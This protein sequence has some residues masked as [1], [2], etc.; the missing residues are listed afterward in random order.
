MAASAAVRALARSAVVLAGALSSSF[1]LADQRYTSAFSTWVAGRDHCAFWN[2][3]VFTLLKFVSD[4]VRSDLIRS[5][6]SF[7]VSER[8]R[9]ACSDE[10]GRLIST[11]GSVARG[12]RP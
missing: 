8:F 10:V 5:S 9:K 2:F 4:L 3:T 1:T 12:T 7:S 6:V 11:L